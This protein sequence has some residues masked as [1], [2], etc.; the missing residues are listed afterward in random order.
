V[1]NPKPEK[2]VKYINNNNFLYA[3]RGS[4]KTILINNLIINILNEF[5]IILFS[6]RELGQWK[7]NKS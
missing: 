1:E 4:G 7:S 3:G 5:K 6:R 2:L